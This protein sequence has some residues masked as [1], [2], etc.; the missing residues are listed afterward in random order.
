MAEVTTSL[1]KQTFNKSRTIQLRPID[2]YTAKEDTSESLHESKVILLKDEIAQKQQILK[3]LEEKQTTLLANVESEISQKRLAWETEREKLIQETKEQGFK[4]GFKEGQ[5]AGQK[6]YEGLL[7][8]VNSLVALAKDDYEKTIKRS[9]EA[10]VKLAMTVAEKILDHQLD[11]NPELFTNIVQSV[12]LQLKDSDS[13]EIYVHPTY[14][15][16]V[17]NKKD[18]YEQL[19]R[20]HTNLQIFANQNLQQTDC[21]VEHTYGK[22]D[23][24]IEIQLEQLETVLVELAMEKTI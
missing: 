8:H 1:S 4:E 16:S 22:V 21:I 6:E 5:A 15:E 2:Y 9:E 11:E 14:F 10:I 24:S 23:A 20:Q 13:V 17:L 19:L 7:D 18:K 3:Q 12:L